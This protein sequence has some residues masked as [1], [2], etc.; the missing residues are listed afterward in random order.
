M[1][2]VSLILSNAPLH[3][4]NF[5][6]LS[7]IRMNSNSMVSISDLK[8]SF[9][10]KKAAGMGVKTCTSAISQTAIYIFLFFLLDT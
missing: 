5:K 8:R 7:Y 10:V 6:V 1:E 2:K 3:C 4:S 9:P